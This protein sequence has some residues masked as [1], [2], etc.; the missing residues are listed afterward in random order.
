[1]VTIR[2]SATLHSRFAKKGA[3]VAPQVVDFKVVRAIGFE[4]TQGS[5]HQNL[6]ALQFIHNQ[7][8]AAFMCRSWPLL[9]IS[10]LSHFAYWNRGG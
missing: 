3:V 9:A 2:E 7:L 1:M 5:P 8:L 4:P 10:I 6:N